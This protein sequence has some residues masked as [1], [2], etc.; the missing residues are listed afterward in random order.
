MSPSLLFVH[1]FLGEAADWAALR[2]ALGA[3]LP[4]SCCELPGHGAAP[5]IAAPAERWFAAAAERLRAACAGHATPPVVVGYSMGGRLALYT[6][7]R[8]PQAASGLVLLG[9]DPGLEDAALRAE[10]L[11]RDRELARQLA[12]SS[13]GEA[14]YAWLQRWYAAPLFGDLRHQPRFADLLQRRLRQRPDYLAAAL[15]GLSVAVQPCLWDL[16]PGL[17]IPALYVAGSGDRKYRAIAARIAALG[18]PW[19]TA[20]CAGAGHAVHLEQPDAVADLIRTF[21]AAAPPAR[22]RGGV[23]DPAG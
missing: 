22:G 2:A 10:R 1:G 11:A 7:L 9:A 13:S 4:S 15:R 16:L 21:A 17:P 8:Y 6:A 20:V 23:T 12:A 18:G 5:P 14:F 19:Q 3:T